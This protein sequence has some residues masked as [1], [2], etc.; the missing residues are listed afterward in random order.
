MCVCVDIKNARRYIISTVEHHRYIHTATAVTTVTRV[1]CALANG[2]GARGPCG[3]Q[4][5]Q[6]EERSAVTTTAGRVCDFGAGILFRFLFVY[7]PLYPF[8]WPLVRFTR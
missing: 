3:A 4:V 5:P 6:E 2:A 7:G 8:S 1:V